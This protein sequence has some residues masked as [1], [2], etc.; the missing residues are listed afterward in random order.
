VRTFAVVGKMF[1]F[2]AQ[3]GIARDGQLVALAVTAGFLLCFLAIAR[4]L[5]LRNR[6][7]VSALDNMSQGLCM[8]DASGRILVSNQ[9]Y[10][11]MYSLSPTVVKPG[12]TL[13]E[14]I[15]H[16][17]ASG[18]FVGDVDEYC[19]KILAQVAQGKTFSFNVKATDGRLVRTVNRPM[20]NGGWVAT[21]DDITEQQEL[22][23][24][25]D[26]MVAHEKRRSMVDAAISVFRD[27]M[28]SMV[29]MMGN[30]AQSMKATATSLSSSSDQN[31]QRAE[32]AA[33]ASNEAA[34]NVASAASAADELSGSIAEI[35]RQL[36]QTN[37][38]VR[39]SVDEAKAMDEQ[40]A[41]LA[42]AAQKIGDVIKL[43]GDIA[44]QTNLL[45]LNATI[46]AARAGEAGRGFAV[47]ASEVKSLAVQTAKATENITGQISS[48]Q[49]ATGSAVEAI[50]RIAE[51]MREINGY[52]SAV[53]AS[54]EQQNAATGQ[55]SLG[56]ANAA[57]ESSLI[58][59]VLGE[60][61]GAASE[62]RASA[63]T[64][65]KASQ[66]VESA[67]ANLC[68]EVETFLAKAAA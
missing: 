52:T 67:V 8:F 61:S 25:R 18:H 1:N 3:F 51:R 23:K 13:R 45:A 39:L 41:A 56:V 42:T 17:K 26:E 44:A 19:R 9:P 5:Q 28:Q 31:A 15:E 62:T 59:S 27:Q 38:V 64:M 35:G 55:I 46:E 20:P 48:V 54:V 16:R 43:I 36:E 32:K 58:V 50:R 60:V 33:K 6:R 68:R 11:Q 63:Q 40:I 34:A 49:T 24:Q 30:A 7:S 53:A 37:T 14:L 12:C 66:S 57:R 2:L 10:L 47:V 29:K 4:P 21:H 22:E 65:L